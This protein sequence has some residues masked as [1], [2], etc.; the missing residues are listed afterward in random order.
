MRQLAAALI[1]LG[2]L[3]APAAHA[4]GT[5][6][7]LVEPARHAL[8]RPGRTP[9]RRAAR[10]VRAR[11]F[12][13]VRFTRRHERP[14]L[15]RPGSIRGAASAAQ[16]DG[17]IWPNSAALLGR[18]PPTDEAEPCFHGPDGKLDV[19]VTSSRQ[20]GRLRIPRGAAAVASP[21]RHTHLVSI[22]GEFTNHWAINDSETCGPVGDGTL[23][24]NFHQTVPAKAAVKYTIERRWAIADQ[25]GPF[26]QVVFLPPQ[27]VV[28]TITRVDNTEPRKA[29]GRDCED[30]D[31]KSGCG[32]S[33]L[34]DGEASVFAH[35]RDGS[36]IRVRMISDEFDPATGDCR[37][38]SAELFGFPP[39]LVGGLDR[40]A[41]AVRMPSAEEFARRNEVTVT[42]TTHDSRMERD[43][44]DGRTWSDDITR[45]VTVTFTKLRRGLRAD[46]GGPYT[47]V[48]GERLRLDGSRSR[49]RGR[50][51]SYRWTFKRAAA[52][53]P[54]ALPPPGVARRS[55]ARAAQ[56]GGCRPEHGGKTGKAPKVLPL[57]TIKATLTVRDAGESDSDTTTITVKP[58]DW[59]TPVADLEPVRYTKWGQPQHGS[60]DGSTF[61]LN[62]PGCGGAARSIR[63]SYFCPLPDGDTWFDEA[64]AL[65]MVVDPKGPHD[66]HWYVKPRPTFKIRR[67]ELVNAY[68]YAGAGVPAGSS[69][70]KEFYAAN[71]EA[72]FPIDD[73]IR[74]VENHEGPG[75][76]LA[77][78]GHTQAIAE[79]IRTEPDS[80][81][82]QR[83]I[84]SVVEPT[85]RA[86]RTE[87]DKRLRGA[88]ERVCLNTRDPL[89]GPWTRG[90]PVA[91]DPTF[92][93]FVPLQGAD[94]EGDPRDCAGS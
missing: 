27:P 94:F 10:A 85:E 77:R 54:P 66:G 64:Y 17:R 14:G 35:V 36:R 43:D 62:V 41:I 63:D 81:D 30:A 32:T 33:P 80:N 82:P 75:Q 38:G 1:V 2:A 31:D 23:S 42:G 39:E 25:V 68:L 74:Y 5:D 12:P 55:A 90:N 73:F 86:A 18:V 47:A 24:V 26:N 76:G 48:R 13:A 60:K 91:W 72:G 50:I 8:V 20:I 7:L 6:G 29:P 37:I 51:D 52:L 53:G 11:G 34:T 45:S 16:I 40:G 21:F 89:A 92:K 46:A 22:S 58:R 44:E 4:A 57:C 19:Y 9:A 59:K 78:S 28:G 71:K 79:A 61:G 49:P 69:A 93:D 84:E 67:R 65:D 3:S 15:V 87:A 83:V 88:G 70:P 56:D